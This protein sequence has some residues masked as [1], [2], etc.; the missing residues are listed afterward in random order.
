VPETA[1]H[2]DADAESALDGAAA[3]IAARV[4]QFF[5]ADEFGALVQLVRVDFGTRREV[6]VLQ[7]EVQRVH[8]QLGR[9]VFERR[10]R[11]YDNC[12]LLGARHAR[13]GPALI[14]TEC[15]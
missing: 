8:V 14:D 9:E 1:P 5:P 13:A 2:V 10:A 15:G 4:C 7:V 12:G 6:G 3:G 11:E